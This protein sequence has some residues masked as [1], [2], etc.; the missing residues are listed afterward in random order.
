M[1]LNE[2][3]AGA[4]SMAMLVIALFFIRFWFRTRDRIF[5]FFSASFLA[6]MIERV[7]RAAMMTETDWAPYV[8]SIRLVAFVLIIV[9]IIDKNR[10]T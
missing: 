8:Y 7:V 5:L 6:L 4:A 10:R 9:A 1:L 2:F 3:F